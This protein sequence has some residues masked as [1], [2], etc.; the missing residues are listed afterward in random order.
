MYKSWHFLCRPPHNQPSSHLEAPMS[1]PNQAM[2]HCGQQTARVA[3]KHT[4][5]FH[6]FFQGQ[7][8]NTW[9]N[10]KTNPKYNSCYTCC[11]C[12]LLRGSVETD[13]NRPSGSFWA[14]DFPGL[15]LRSACTRAVHLSASLKVWKIAEFFHYTVTIC[16]RFVYFE[17]SCLRGKAK[18][19]M[20]PLG[21]PCPTSTIFVSNVFL[22]FVKTALF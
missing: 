8:R 12:L 16:D 19:E 10:S 14:T 1:C 11:T 21:S 6:G 5:N 4:W 22:S 3:Q 7:W 20:E 18:T 13:H 9:Q 15:S 2:W 17:V